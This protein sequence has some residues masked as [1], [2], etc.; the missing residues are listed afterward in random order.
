M[1][2]LLLAASAAYAQGAGGTIKGSVR[3]QNGAV[4]AGALV[5]ITNNSTGEKRSATTNEQGDYTVPNLPVGIYTVTANAAGF[6][7]KT[8][9]EV[10]VSVSFTTDADLTVSPAGATESVTVV[11]S[12]DT[13]TAVNTTDQQLST[14]ISNQ[15]ILDLPLL[16]RN[17]NS[18]VLLAPGTTTSD[19]RLGGIVVNGQRERNNN[20]QVDGVDNNDTEVPG[21]SFGVATPS[22]DGTQEF[23]VLTSSYNAEFGRNSGAIIN[24][25]TKSGTNQFHGNAYIYYRSDAFSARDFFD[26][27]G[28]P[29]PLQRRQW[30]G[31]IGGPVRKDKTFFFVNYE[32]DLFDQGQ[33]NIRIVPSALARQGILQTGAANFGTLDIRRNGAN[34]ASADILGFDQ[35]LGINP[36]ITELLN[37][38]YPLGNSPADATLP[39]VFDAFRFSSVLRVNDG[40]QLTSRVDTKLNE[41]HNLAGSF[42]F[43]KGNGD[44]FAESFPGRNDGGNAPYKS[45]NVG[46][47]LASVF[48]PNLINELRLGVN[49]VE[50]RFNLPGTGG[51][52]TGAYGETLTAF[53]NNGVPRATTVFGGENGRLIDLVNTGISDLNT[54]GIDSQFRFTGTTTLGDSL[55]VIR[56]NQTWKFGGEARWV[57]SNGANNFFR[58]E[59]LDFSLSQFGIPILVDNNGDTLPTNGL[60]GTIQN[61]ADFLYGLVVN[62]QQWQYYNKSGQRVDADYLGI[63]QREFDLFAQNNWKVRPNLT[64]NLGLRWEYKGVPYEVNGQLSNLIGQDPSGPTPAGGFRFQTV[65]KNSANPHQPLYD[66]DYNN[67]APRVGFNYSPGFNSGW[68]SKLTGGPGNM[69]VRGGYGVYY[70]RVFGNIVRNSSTNPPFQ[71]TFNNFPVDILQNVA[72]PTTI[73]SD[74]TIE[75]G[76][77]LAVN[78]FP[79]AGNN[80]FQQHFAT[81][82][83]QTWNFGFQRQFMG[84]SLVEADYIGS[85]GVNLLRALDAQA[86]SVRRINAITGANNAIN[87]NSTRANYLNGVLNTAFGSTGAVV[88]VGLGHSTYNAM[89]LRFTKRLTES[90]FGAGQFQA[91][92]TWSHS[93]DNAP[94]P[95]D[96]GRGN[97]SL[98]R[99]SSGFAG[100]LTAERG[101]SDFDTRHRFVANFIYELP[102]KSSNGVVNQIV[103][104]WSVTGIVTLQSGTPFSIFGNVDSGGTGLSQRASFAAAGQG[105]SPTANETERARTQV[106]PSRSLFRQPVAGEIGNV[107]RNSF[108]GDGYQ[109]TD[110]SVIK[111]FPLSESVKL[112]IQADFFNLFNN[113]NLFNPSNTLGQNSIGQTTFGQSSTAFPAR[114]IQFAARIDF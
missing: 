1:F 92:Y 3:D 87:P 81:P 101:N 97:R 65:G 9:K 35:N 71:N 106:G 15:K 50:V 39:G 12:T 33:Q 64:L 17:P 47:N 67:F 53:A 26:V 103:G 27:S 38:V 31:S 75:D 37:R 6:A 110:L 42:N 16:S 51:E 20:L 88:N 54:L 105:L 4:V 61:Y 82:Y 21:G 76:A 57:Y 96:A 109:N 69:S 19:S 24:I 63:R 49:R 29:D 58:K 100:G 74:A 2:A 83:T 111:R 56:G 32:R 104:N 28:Q 86:A 95:L 41:K 70:D 23:R 13:Q 40:H 62:Q 45:F 94:D 22:I 59:F 73:G 14:L 89:A 46:L 79:L 80:I 36:A 52:P 44:I 10:N 11:S 5:D 66:E 18:L 25:V 84:N 107:Q 30:G 68:L 93:I 90:S 108:Y 114:R 55:T 85:H 43:T 102:F 60:G 77:E 113:V 78:L 91:A 112:R 99:D 7:P 48:S 98:P 72:R 8:A 34:N